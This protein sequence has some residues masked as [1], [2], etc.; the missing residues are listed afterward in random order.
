MPPDNDPVP[1]VK[2]PGSA[3]ACPGMNVLLPLASNCLMGLGLGS[4]NTWLPSQ[5]FPLSQLFLFPKVPEA[6]AD[7]RMEGQ[8]QTPT[9]TMI[10]MTKRRQQKRG[11]RGNKL[12]ARMPAWWT[13]DCAPGG[14]VRYPLCAFL[15][16]PPLPHPPSVLYCL[17]IYVFPLEWGTL[18]VLHN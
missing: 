17:L 7:V 12:Q 3:M 5:S 6:T 14:Y 8:K 9:A 10:T 13:R 16:S 1:G 11:H 15:H 2:S 4:S 18:T